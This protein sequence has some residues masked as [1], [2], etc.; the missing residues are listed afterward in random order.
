MPAP[1]IAAGAGLA[2]SIFAGKSENK[3]ISGLAPAILQGGTGL[4]GSLLQSGAAK[5]AAKSQERSAA[6]ALDFERDNERRRRFEFDQD[7]ADRMKAHEAR[8]RAF[9]PYRLAAAGVLKKYIPQ[10]DFNAVPP[11]EQIQTLEPMVAE[12]PYT[13]GMLARGR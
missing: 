10:Y 4:A 11:E 2:G 12:D 13:L 8:E 3:G 6:A 7:R 9:E 5:D 1:I